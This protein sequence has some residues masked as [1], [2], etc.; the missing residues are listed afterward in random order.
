MRRAIATNRLE[1]TNWELLAALRHSRNHQGMEDLRDALRQITGRQHVFLAPSCRSAIA[2]ILTLL[3]H[4]DVILPAYTCWVLKPAAELAGK[5]L[6]YIDNP[7]NA[8]NTTSREYA[9]K[10]RPGSVLIPTHLFGIPTDIENICALARQHN[11]VTIED[12]AAGFG[13]RRNGRWLGT[14]A[15]FGVF[16]F[17]RSK[18]LPAFRGAAIIVNNEKLIDPAKLA[19]Q[20]VADTT[21]TFPWRDLSFAL[22][23]NLATH[24]SVYGSLRALKALRKA[25]KT[26]LVVQSDAPEVPLQTPFYNRALHPYQAGLLLRMLRR[27][28]R[29]RGHIALL[30]SIYL[31]VFRDSPIQTFLNDS[32]RDHGGLLRFPIAFPRKNRAEI[33]TLARQRGFHLETNYDEPLADKPDWPQFPNALWAAQNIVLLPLYKSLSPHDAEQ[34]AR[35]VVA[36]EREASSSNKVSATTELVGARLSASQSA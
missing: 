3:P 6:V 16:S 21:Q 17:E 1:T 20:R 19:A 24:P 32:D 29:I 30:V 36:I 25:A 7:P 2:Q 11:C 28:D 10:I 34:L 27:M 5:R 15:D 9:A 8:I 33:L 26:H 14:F 4:Q 35:A 23:H 13:A 18:R 31:Q 22:A 12:V